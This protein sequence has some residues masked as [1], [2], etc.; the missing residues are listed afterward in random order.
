MKKFSVI[1]LCVVVINGCGGSSDKNNEDQESSVDNILVGADLSDLDL[2]I[3]TNEQLKN[4]FAALAD[5]NY[6]DNF[7]SADPSIEVVQRAGKLI[8]DIGG[9]PY[10][11]TPNEARSSWGEFAESSLNNDLPY[12]NGFE[13]YLGGFV[14][15]KAERIAEG[16]DLFVYDYHDCSMVEGTTFVNGRRYAVDKDGEPFSAYYHGLSVEVDNMSYGMFGYIEN[17]YE[18]STE[19]FRQYLLLQDTQSSNSIFV[20]FTREMDRSNISQRL[21]SFYGYVYFENFGGVEIESVAGIDLGTNSEAGHILFRGKASIVSLEFVNVLYLWPERAFHDPQQVYTVDE[22]RDGIYDIGVYFDDFFGVPIYTLSETTLVSIED[23][24]I[25][26]ISR[27][28]EF[29]DEMIYEDYSEIIVE[30]GLVIDPD[31]DEG[32]I[33]I[34]FRWYVND[35]LQDLYTTN[36]FPSGLAARGDTVS[37]VQVVF[38]GVNAIE[39]EPAEKEISS[40]IL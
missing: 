28:P 9:I 14:N 18:G 34:S 40:N 21:D 20:N 33:L 27:R 6:D 32:D 3:Y 29:L 22:D 4:A 2:S 8:L 1:I 38:D 16:Y 30:A 25:A 19:Y 31:T 13:C 7:N 11:L 26:P 10:P 36:I 23:M 5:S 37:V 15:M 35:E 24:S 17:H 12:E 39:S